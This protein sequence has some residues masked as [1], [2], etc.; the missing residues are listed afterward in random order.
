MDGY[1]QPLSTCQTDVLLLL[2]LP[3]Q[4]ASQKLQDTLLA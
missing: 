4:I 3:G 1:L 2:S